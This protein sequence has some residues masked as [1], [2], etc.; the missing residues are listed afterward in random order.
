MIAGELCSSSMFHLA[1]VGKEQATFSLRV[2]IHVLIILYYVQVKIL[3]WV[4]VKLYDGFTI[5]AHLHRFS[6]FYR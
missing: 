2:V 4:H 5:M 1:L 3:I 6:Q